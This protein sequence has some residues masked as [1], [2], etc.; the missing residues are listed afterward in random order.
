[1]TGRSTCPGEGETV[2]NITQKDEKTTIHSMLTISKSKL[3][4]PKRMDQKAFPQ[5]CA[6]NGS[7]DCA[8]RFALWIVKIFCRARCFCQHING[9]N[10][11]PSLFYS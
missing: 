6:N 7:F 2:A 8:S 3:F 4:S 11:K 10:G 1:M 9:I 5:C